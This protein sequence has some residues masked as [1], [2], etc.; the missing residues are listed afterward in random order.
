[1]GWPHFF[2][3]VIIVQFGKSRDLTASGQALTCTDDFGLL[4]PCELLA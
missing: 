4:T 2:I 1:V 3:Y